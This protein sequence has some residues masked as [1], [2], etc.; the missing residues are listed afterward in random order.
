MTAFG[1]G[2]A[3]NRAFM[4]KKEKIDVIVDSTGLK[5]YGEGE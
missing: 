1:C 2:Y 3:V 4:K 5:V